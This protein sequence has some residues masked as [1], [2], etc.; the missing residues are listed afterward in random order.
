VEINSFGRLE[1]IL[2]EYIEL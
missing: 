1:T 2:G